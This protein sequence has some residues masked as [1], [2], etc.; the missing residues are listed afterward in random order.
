LVPQVLGEAIEAQFT[1]DV[2]YQINMTNEED[3]EEE[4]MTPQERL[5][6][7]ENDAVEILKTVMFEDDEL[8]NLVHTIVYDTLG[9]NTANMDES[10]PRYDMFYATMSMVTARLF[11]KAGAEMY[12]PSPK[13]S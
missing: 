6:Q 11:A 9:Y 12:Y 4:L 2:T 10:D 8:S 3:Y 5:A 7:N 1:E 13:A